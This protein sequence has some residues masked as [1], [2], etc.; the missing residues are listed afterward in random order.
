MACRP[1]TGSA[2]LAD[3]QQALRT[4]TFHTAS[5]TPT[6]FGA[7]PDPESISSTVNDGT[8]VSNTAQTTVTVTSVNDTPENQAT[9]MTVTED[10]ASPLTGIVFTDPDAAGN[11]VAGDAVVA[12]GSLAA[13]SAAASPSAARRAP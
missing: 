13:A 11:T 4:V 3:F 8:L 10:V 6:D 7:I 2:P 1:V 12:S 5:D 9:S